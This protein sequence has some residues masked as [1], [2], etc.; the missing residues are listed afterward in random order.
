[1]KQARNIVTELR[2][3]RSAKGISPKV[4]LPVFIK[5]E[6]PTPIEK[7]K[8][9]L[10]K[11]GNIASLEINGTIPEGATALVVGTDELYIPL[12][13]KAGEADA[14]KA[15]LE[16]ELAYQIGFLASVEAKLANEK[17]VNNAKPDLVEKE[18]Q[19]QADAHRE[20]EAG[21]QIK[22]GVVAD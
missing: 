5:T 7:H 18:R 1:M 13:K 10:T 6:T 2:N 3:L 15:E 20:G 21:K 11:M 17:F 8:E 22:H 12:E 19:K 16:K 4:A 9:L 14:E